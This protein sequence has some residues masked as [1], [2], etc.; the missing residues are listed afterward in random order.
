MLSQCGNHKMPPMEI[1]KEK[2]GILT[3]K[4]IN[5][6]IY[7]KKLFC[8]K[9]YNSQCC[10]GNVLGNASWII[11]LFLVKA[12]K[13]SLFKRAK[14]FLCCDVKV[15]ENYYNFRYYCHDHD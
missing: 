4:C 6:K 2:L 8:I 7:L 1:I 10:Y 3:Y 14:M 13:D 11:F 15:L 9:V 5:W 12:M